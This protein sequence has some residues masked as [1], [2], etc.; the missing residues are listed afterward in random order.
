MEIENKSKES[1][2]RIFISYE[3]PKDTT[4]VEGKLQMNTSFLLE[5]GEKLFIYKSEPSNGTNP[6]GDK[7]MTKTQ[8]ENFSSVDVKDRL[9]FLESEIKKLRA[10][11]TPNVGSIYKAGDFWLLCI[12][13]DYHKEQA[14]FKF[15]ST[16]T[17]ALR[18]RVYSSN[19]NMNR[20]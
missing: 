12:Q 1:Q 14:I 17:E 7:I 16:E 5:P 10:A 9:E 2:M 8:L 6:L 4:W 18:D 11:Y 3:V 15:F 19:P 13:A 20:G